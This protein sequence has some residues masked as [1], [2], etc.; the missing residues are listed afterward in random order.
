MTEH[1]GRFNVECN[2]IKSRC[3]TSLPVTFIMQVQQKIPLDS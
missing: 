1:V 3:Q 2:T